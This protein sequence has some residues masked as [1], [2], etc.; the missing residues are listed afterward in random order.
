MNVISVGLL[1]PSSSIRPKMGKDFERAF[2][3]NLKSSLENTPYEL[4]IVRELI[5]HG[6][7]AKIEGALD[8]F[9]G[10]EDVDV[11]VSLAS[12]AAIQAVVNQFEKK[13]TPLINN[14]LGEHL[15]SSTAFNDYIFVNSIHL[16]QQ[17][18]LLGQYAR[19]TFGKR[20]LMV[21]SVYD[22]G[23]AFV[24]AFNLG[25][26]AERS[27]SFLDL[28]F[29]NVLENGGLLN[30]E[31]FF[32]SIDISSIDFVFS[33]FCGEEATA[34][35][36]GFKKS[37]WMKKV[38]ILGLPFLLEPNDESLNEVS[39]ITP[40]SDFKSSAPDP[41]Y[42]NIFTEFGELSGMTIAKAI[43]DGGGHLN[44]EGIR[45]ALF[46]INAE[47]RYE[48]NMFPEL[49][50]KVAI[51]KNTFGPSNEL[52]SECMKLETVELSEHKE[53]ALL[54]DAPPSGWLNPYLC[55]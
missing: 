50:N 24:S 5:G 52:T 11:V 53:L 33:L 30:I 34:F 41:R 3:K 7:I 9:F 51:L 39:V 6:N 17:C 8:N 26:Q 10:F 22:T 38:P 46:E 40:R 47:R 25:M 16:W 19:A 20:G 36:E 18:F 15:I 32:G 4:E 21:G 28:K 14:N 48:S 2:L 29:I 13:K 49:L 1:L 45:N 44:S 54:G 43:L 35:L 23:Y 12:N 37:N 31:P 27:G 42:K 55:I